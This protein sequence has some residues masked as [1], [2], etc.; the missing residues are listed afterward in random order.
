M[1]INDT[2][3]ITIF[4]SLLIVSLII[5]LSMYSVNRYKTN[6]EPD[7][8][9]L[10]NYLVNDSS[11]AKTNKP[12]LWIHNSYEINSREWESFGSRNSNNLNKPVIYLTVDSIIKNCNNSF[13]ICII[14]DN[15][16]NN[17]IPGWIWDLDTMSEPIKSYYRYLA[18][19]KLINLY[20]GLNVP[21]SFLCFRDLIDIYNNSISEKKP[22][23]CESLPCY[24]KCSINEYFIGC[25]KNSN[26]FKKNMEDLEEIL[27][28]NK[29]A[30]PL[31]KNEI[32]NYFK[33]E[34]N[35]NNI[36]LV[37]GVYLGLFDTNMN[38][39]NID[40]MLNDNDVVINEQAY[41]INIPIDE[42]M[43]MFKYQWFSKLNVDEIVESNTLI[44]KY[45][46]YIYN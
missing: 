25:D 29:T 41:G 40:T 12:V 14:D 23:I 36:I 18:I 38:V 35:D 19:L 42:I 17:L 16:F 31:F 21:S 4:I 2:V 44:G 13:K 11:L 30:E 37:E 27:S 9:L 39:I 32:S 8:D 1:K 5:Y 3:G 45:L 7:Y 28:N 33:Q 34:I 43:N 24:D 6:E 15:S 20:G 46:N 26:T 22:L 10:Q